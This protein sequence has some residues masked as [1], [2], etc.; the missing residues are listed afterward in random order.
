MR[1][2]L[3]KAATRTDY[4]VVDPVRVVYELRT[5]RHYDFGNYFARFSG[6]YFAC[7]YPCLELVPN[8]GAQ[9]LYQGRPHEPTT[10]AKLFRTIREIG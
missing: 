6:R 10:P 8:S 3:M 7:F 4:R 5:V 9:K 2:E 1:P